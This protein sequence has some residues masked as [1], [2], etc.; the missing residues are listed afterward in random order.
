MIIKDQLNKIFSIGLMED[1]IHYRVHF[2][3]IKIS[4]K[5]PIFC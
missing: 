4:F 3:G 5:R 1:F 2:L